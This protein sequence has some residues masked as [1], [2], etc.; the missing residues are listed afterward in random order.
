MISAQDPTA[1]A[2]FYLINHDIRSRAVT[3]NLSDFALE[4]SIVP[5]TMRDT[6]FVE[7]A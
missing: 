5:E 2:G 7:G 1:H 6:A 4:E 3:N